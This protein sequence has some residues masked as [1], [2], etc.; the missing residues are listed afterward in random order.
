MEPAVSATKPGASFPLNE[1][2][3]QSTLIDLLLFD[4]RW[5]T[6]HRAT[7]P[8]LSCSKIPT[9]LVGLAT[10]MR[11]YY[12]DTVKCVTGDRWTAMVYTSIYISTTNGPRGRIRLQYWD[13]NSTAI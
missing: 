1:H 8:L 13:D 5:M 10:P 6:S 4:Q 9:V 7:E 3:T 2:I 12:R 11:F